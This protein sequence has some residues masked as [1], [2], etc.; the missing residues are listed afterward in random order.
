MASDI[1]GERYKY[2]LPNRSESI[3]NYNNQSIRI[4]EPYL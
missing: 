2:S 1:A 3:T 4:A